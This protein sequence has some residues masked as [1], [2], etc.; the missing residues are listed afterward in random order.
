MCVLL[1]IFLI[2]FVKFLFL[3]LYFFVFWHVF[4]TYFQNF[5]IYVSFVL[6]M[7]YHHHVK[8]LFVLLYNT[9]NTSCLVWSLHLYQ[10]YCF[11]IWWR[12]WC[13]C[14]CFLCNCVHYR[15]CLLMMLSN[16]ISKHLF[17]VD[18]HHQQ[19]NTVRQVLC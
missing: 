13:W 9:L 1:V 4:L 6:V 7:C 17:D 8:S 12:W 5:E 19:T 15:V 10:R 18:Q 11:F 14:A 3:N 16:L 2:P